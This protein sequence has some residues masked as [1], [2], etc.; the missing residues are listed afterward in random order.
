MPAPDSTPGAGRHGGPMRLDPAD[1]K[2]LDES[3]VSWRRIAALFRP[4]R[5]RISLV[6]ILLVTSALAGLATPFLT[7]MIIDDALPHSNVRLLLWGVAGMIGV[8]ALTSV[9]GVLQTWQSTVV[10]QKV[11]HRLRTDVFTHLQKQSLAFF[12]RTRGGEVQ[13]RITNDVNAMQG[14]VTDTATSIATNITLV[15]GTAVAMVAMSWRLS[16]LS[17]IVLPPAIWVSRKV[18]TMRREVTSQRQRTMSELLTQVEQTLT[19]SGI[20]LTKTLGASDMAADRFADTSAEL[21]DLEVRSQLAGRWRMSTMSIVFATLPALLYLAAG[22]PATSGGM[23]IGTL[24]AFVALQSS[25]FRPVM[26]LLNTSVQVVSSMALFSRIFGYLDLPVEVAEPAR[27]VQLDPDDV[28]GELR[29]QHVG[30][31]YPGADV[32]AI[33]DVDLVVSPGQTL[34]LVGETGSGK[35]TLAGLVARLADPTQG[36][37]TIDGVDLRDLPLATVASLVGVV[38]QETFLL[39]T[40]IAENLRYAKPSATDAEL[41]QAL[42]TAQVADV[43]A[44]LPEGL[45]TVVGARGQRF[46]GGEQQRLAIARTVLRDPR[47]LVL[48]EATSALDNETE[49]ELQEALDALVVGRTTVTIAHRLSTV[50]D[51]DTIAV[52]DH[53]RVAEAGSPADLLSRGGRYAALV[54]ASEVPA[55]A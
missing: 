53:G 1:R 36:R 3:P 16:L 55:A 30:F 8:A 22:F 48:D 42:E 27:P 51:A 23:T 7:R 5:A 28:R 50:R 2:Q 43:V 12:T 14:V 33:A 21:A 18:A 6:M 39:H 29:F 19:V 41:W 4:Y 44:A 34:A 26:G 37:I 32:D 25:V 49:R 38:S 20:R 11:M 24:V 45:Q 17:L 10:G 40:T 46:S 31:R 15:I 9:L 35:S 13:S 52:L 47:I 54:A